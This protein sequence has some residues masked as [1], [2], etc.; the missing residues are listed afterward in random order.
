[1]LGVPTRGPLAGL[2]SIWRIASAREPGYRSRL[3]LGTLPYV[4]VAAL[5][6]IA[7]LAVVVAVSLVAGQL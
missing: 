2:G 4:G 7:V 5:T 1:M 6:L 3:Y